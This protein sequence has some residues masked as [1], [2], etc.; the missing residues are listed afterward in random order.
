MSGRLFDK[1]SDGSQGA[2]TYRDH[3][4]A[5]HY[6]RGKHYVVEVTHSWQ[7]FTEDRLFWLYGPNYRAERQAMTTADIA[8]WN[9]LGLR[10]AA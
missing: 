8:A 9:R 1:A 4:A 2:S 10:G 5:P 7:A 3:H 6:V